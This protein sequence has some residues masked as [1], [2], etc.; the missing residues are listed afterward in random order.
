MVGAAGPR[1]CDSGV[2][3]ARPGR[4]CDCGPVWRRQR[5]VAGDPLIDALEQHRDLLQVVEA[6]DVEAT[7][8][9]RRPA[10]P[11]RSCVRVRPHSGLDLMSSTR[12]RYSG[13]GAPRRETV[14][15]HAQ[16]RPP[17]RSGLRQSAAGHGPWFRGRVA[18]QLA[19]FV[20]ARHRRVDGQEARCVAEF[21]SATGRWP[22]LVHECRLSRSP[23][24]TKPIGCAA[25]TSTAGLTSAALPPQDDGAGAHGLQ[26]G[27][28]PLLGGARAHTRTGFGRTT[29]TRSARRRRRARPT[30]R[31]FAS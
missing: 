9:S 28:P 1:S 24:P 23:S 2:A 25:Q 12:R 14:Q 13:G 19:R 15:V 30:R 11:Q 10:A 22:A 18:G 7:A 29:I 6:F 17:I 16:P 31:P 8:A 5:R 3:V 26:A 27:R 21:G 20:V 4:S